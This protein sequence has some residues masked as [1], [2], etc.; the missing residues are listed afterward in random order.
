MAAS[1][2]DKPPADD[3]E[4]M[5]RKDE[6]KQEMLKM[7]NA[8]KEMNKKLEEQTKQIQTLEK[9]KNL[10]EQEGKK[11]IQDKETRIKVLQTEKEKEVEAL[12]KQLEKEKL[13]PKDSP[14][15]KGTSYTNSVLPPIKKGEETKPIGLDSLEKYKSLC[16]ECF[17]KLPRYVMASANMRECYTCRGYGLATDRFPYGANPSC[18]K[19]LC[20]TK[21]WDK[22]KSLRI[23]TICQGK[24]GQELK[25]YGGKY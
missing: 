2:Y 25:I 14:P 19:S 22:V 3:A 21:G 16:D 13:K 17:F 9:E 23:C 6:E 24:G 5:R 1:K 7:A 20:F 8:M 4:L 11:I 18:E 15:P 12:K 10:K